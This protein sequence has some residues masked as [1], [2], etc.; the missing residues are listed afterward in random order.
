MPD[1]QNNLSG[2]PRPVIAEKWWSV[3]IGGY[4]RASYEQAE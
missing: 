1:E 3:Q 2:I 4:S